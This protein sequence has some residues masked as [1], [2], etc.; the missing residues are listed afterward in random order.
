MGFTLQ[1]TKGLTVLNQ[2]FS[3]F[4]SI[5]ASLTDLNGVIAQLDMFVQ[6]GAGRAAAVGLTTKMSHCANML[7]C[8]FAAVC[9]KGSMYVMPAACIVRHVVST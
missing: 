5:S 3:Y 2:T 8:D 1:E 4:S 9:V 7:R 6:R